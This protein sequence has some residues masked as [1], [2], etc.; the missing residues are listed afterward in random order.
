ME[1]ISGEIVEKTWKKMAGMS[2]LEAEKIGSLMQKEQPYVLVYL[3]AV[4][5]ANNFTQDEKEVLLYLGTVVW[6]IMSQGNTPLPKVTDKMLDEVEEKNMKMLEY[7][8]SEPEGSFI[9]SVEKIFA[10][11]NQKNVLRYVIETIME[12]KEC[13]IRDEYKGIMAIYLKTIIDCFDV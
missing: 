10:N 12:D 4:G 1:P 11:Y 8:D 7:L 3:L 9:E 13:L 6:Q 2:P 5:D